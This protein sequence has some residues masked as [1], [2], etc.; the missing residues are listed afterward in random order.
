MA[1]YGE[2]RFRLIKLLPLVDLDIIEGWINDRYQ[3]IL[4]RVDWRRKLVVSTFQTAS[5]HS[6]GT[7]SATAKNAA[8]TGSGTNW[9]SEMDGRMIRIAEGNEFYGFTYSSPT[10]A[11]LDRGFEGSTGS[12]LSY[13]IN[14]NVIKM[15]LDV[16]LVQSVESFETGARLQRLSLVELNALDPKRSKYGSPTYWCPYMDAHTDPPVVQIELYP[17]PTEVKGFRV[18]VIAEQDIPSG[19]STTILPWVRPAALIAGVQADAAALA[20]NLAGASYYEAIFEKHVSEMGNI[21]ARRRGA[22]SI[23]VDRSITGRNLR[24][25]LKR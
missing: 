15:P 6:D 12:G 10:D 4:D 5:E 21:E 13:R 20:G 22:Q 19:S 1:T 17:V 7:I 11:T 3:Q 14:Q 8:V 25:L 24:R 16:R 23:R 9:T 18:E 2:I